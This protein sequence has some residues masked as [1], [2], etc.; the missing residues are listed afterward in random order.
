VSAAVLV[1]WVEQVKHQ[2]KGG[3]TCSLVSIAIGRGAGC[4]C[5]VV[6]LV[7]ARCFEVRTRSE[8]Q[9]PLFNRPFTRF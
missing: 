1:L 7:V 4:R 2:G 3:E 6:Y 8:F 9:A 5:R